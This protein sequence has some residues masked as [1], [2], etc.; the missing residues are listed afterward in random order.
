MLVEGWGVKRSENL[1]KEPLPSTVAQLVDWDSYQ[2]L[3]PPHGV[4]ITDIATINRYV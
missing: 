2:S 4:D 1:P 3:G